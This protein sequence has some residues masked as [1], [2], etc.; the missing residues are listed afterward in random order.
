MAGPASR[1]APARSLSRAEWS[2]R[3]ESQ[4]LAPPDELLRE[5]RANTR[6]E[7]G[8]VVFL[9][10]LAREIALARGA[11]L[12]LAYRNLVLVL[13]GFRKK[14]RAGRS[15]VTGE[16]CVVFVVRRKGGVEAGHPQ[17]LPAWLIT[18]ADRNGVRR[19]YA[20]P[21]DVQDAADYHGATAHS[22]SAVWVKNGDWPLV[23]GS[24]ACLVRLCA[25]GAEQTCVMSAQH[26]LT[27]F[28]DGDSLQVAGGLP[29]LP[30]DAQGNKASSPRLG[31]SLPYGGV[32]RGD[33]RPDRPSFDVQ[34]AALDDAAGAAVRLRA[35]LRRL[36]AAQPWVHG[37][38]ELLA[39]DKGGWFH[40]LTPDN[41]GSAPGRGAVRLTLG[42]MPPS[43]V[44]IEYKLAGDPKAVTR[45]VFHAELLRF[46]AVDSKVPVSGD[47]GSPI[48]VR[49][50][51]GSMTLVAMH[52]GGDGQG[53]SWAIPAWRLFDL[54][55]WWQ[56]P[57]GARVEPVDA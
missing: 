20:L 38:A 17:H 14:L 57:A 34:L 52:I 37:T 6:R 35:A 4:S 26:V 2:R 47:S 39:L 16:V 13:P 28:A 24:F 43:A 10:A 49:R 9:A 22:D 18:F 48:V 42:A 40:L 53:L 36:N 21:T 5:A 23:D 44:G 51:D 33:E 11:E 31:V 15:R 46:D 1:R 32:L 55:N 25:A 54:G 27:P 45:M 30:R 50:E 12:T 56:F 8:D 19:P 3:V 7:A 41:H 29:L